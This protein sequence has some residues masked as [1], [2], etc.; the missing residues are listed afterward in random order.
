VE[1]SRIAVGTW[2]VGGLLPADD[3]DLDGFL[4]SSNPADIYVLG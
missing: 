3:I 4:D 2:N 1:W